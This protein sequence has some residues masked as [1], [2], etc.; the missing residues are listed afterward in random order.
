M[1]KDYG[2]AAILIISAVI[3]SA[4]FMFGIPEQSDAATP[5]AHDG[6]IQLESTSDDHLHFIYFTDDYLEL[7]LIDY[8]DL[9]WENAV[10]IVLEQDGKVLTFGPTSA[11]P[12]KG[13]INAF[14]RVW[15]NTFTGTDD[16]F[17]PNKDFTFTVYAH[18][19]HSIILGSCSSLKQVVVTLENKSVQ[20]SGSAQAIGAASVTDI[21]GNPIEGLTVSY[22]YYSD[23]ECTQEIDINQNPIKHADTYYA[24]AFTEAS[25]EY[26][27]GVSNVATLTITPKPLTPTATMTK[28]Y[29]GSKFLQG[30]ASPS[31]NTGISGETVTVSVDS[32]TYNDGVDVGTYSVDLNV[33]LSDQDTDYCLVNQNEQG[34]ASITINNATITPKP[35]AWPSIPSKTYNG[36]TQVAEPDVSEKEYAVGTN[37]GGEDAGFYDIELIL[38]S[39]NYMWKD[40]GDYELSWIQKSFEIVKADVGGIITQYSHVYDGSPHGPAKSDL[41]YTGFNGKSPSDTYVTISDKEGD[42]R[43]SKGTHYVLVSVSGGDKNFNATSEPIEVSF[44]IGKQQVAWPTDIPYAVYD[45]TEKTLTYGTTGKPYTLTGTTKGTDAGF[46]PVTLTLVSDDYVWSGKSDEDLAWTQDS[47][48]IKKGTITGISTTF[49]HEY[50]GTSHVPAKTD[51]AYTGFSTRPADTSVTLTLKEG[52]DGISAGSHT[53]LVSVS[54]DGNFEDTTEPIEISYSISQKGLTINVTSQKYYDGSFLESAITDITADGLVDGDSVS[55]GKVKTT[56]SDVSTYTEQTTDWIISEDFATTKGLSNYD[57]SFGTVTLKIEKAT[58]TE[59]D[60][61][62]EYASGLIYDGTDLTLITTDLTKTGPKFQYHIGDSTDF[63]DDVPTGKTADTYKVYW[64][65]VGGK[66]YNDVAG[67]Y[68]NVNIA[69]RPIIITVSSQSVYSGSQYEYTIK[70]TDLTNLASGDSLSAGKLKTAGSDVS[71]YTASGTSI[72]TQLTISEAIITSYGIG[73]YSI[74][75]NVSLKIT[76]ADPEYTA[77]VGKTGL[78]YDGDEKELITAGSSDDGTFTYSLDGSTYASAIPTAIEPGSYTVYWKLTGDGNHKDASGSVTGITIVNGA[79]SFSWTD[80][81]D[82]TYSGTPKVP[83]VTINGL[84]AEDEGKVSATIKLSDG[85]DNVN[86]GT[87]TYYV[88][89]LTGES[90]SKYD[91]PEQV[92]SSDY[93]ITKKSLAVNISASKTYDGSAFVYTIKQSDLSGLV[94]G[95]SLTKGKITTNSAAVGTYDSQDEYQIS[96]ALAVQNGIANYDVGY[97]VSLVISEARYVLTFDPGMFTVKIGSSDIASGSRVAYNT[98]VTVTASD[99]YTIKSISLDGTQQTSTTGFS[100]PLKDTVLTVETEGA[101]HTITYSVSPEEG[102]SVDE[103][104]TSALSGQT[105]V[106]ADYIHPNEGYSLQSLTYKLNGAGDDVQISKTGFEMPN[107]DITVYVVFVQDAPTLY[108]ITVSAMDN[109]TVTSSSYEA[110]ENEEIALIVV[111]ENGYVLKAGTLV[112]MGETEIELSGSGNT[113]TFTMPAHAVTISA[114][115]ERLYTVT[116]IE[117]EHGILQSSPTSGKAGTEVELTPSA[118][119]GYELDGVYAGDQKITPVNDKYIFTLQA[120]VE[121]SAVFV[122]LYTLTIDDGITGGTVTPSEEGPFKAGASVTLTITPGEEKDLSQ[123]WVAG[124]QVTPVKSGEAYTY[125]FQIQGD[126]FVTAE[127]SDLYSVTINNVTGGTITSSLSGSAPAGTQVTLTVTLST[128]YKLD[129]LVINGEIITISGSTYVFSLQG[130]TTVTAA[131][132]ALSEYTVTFNSNGGTSV[133]SQTVAAGGKVVKPT[134]PTKPSTSTMRYTFAGWYS[135]SALTTAYDFDSIVNSS[136][137]LYAKWIETPI[138]GPSPGPEPTPT[139]SKDKEYNPDG[140]TTESETTTKKDPITGETTT[141]TKSTTTETDGTKTETESKT[142]TGKDG[143]S[144]TESTSTTTNPDGSS[145]TSSTSS[146]STKNSDGTTST[147]SDTMAQSSDGSSSVSKTTSTTSKDGKTT[148]GTTTTTETDADGNVSRTTT[149]FISET[150]KSG[151]DTITTTTETST[152]VNPDGTVTTSTVETK[153]T[154]SSDGSSTEDVTIQ[155]TNPD[156]SKTTETVTTT[157]SKNGKVEKETDTTIEYKDGSSESISSLSET[158][159]SG[160]TTVTETETT[161]TRSD[162]SISKEKDVT[163]IYTNGKV[164]TER[165]TDSVDKDGNETIT[166][167]TTTKT[168]SDVTTESS[169]T[170]TYADGTVTTVKTRTVDDGS[171]IESTVSE[172]TVETDGTV[173]V[174]KTDSVTKDDVTEM[175]INETITFPDG[176]QRVSESSVEQTV[177]EDGSVVSERTLS[178]TDSDGTV[179]ESQSTTTVGE[180]GSMQ[181]S[182]DDR[183]TNPDGSTTDVSLNGTDRRVEVIVS[184]TKEKDIENAMQSLEDIDADIIVIGTENSDGTIILPKESVQL[185]ADAGYQISVNGGSQYVSLDDDVVSYLAD[186]DGDVVLSVVK[187][188]A[189]NTSKA[190]MDTIGDLYAVQVTLTVNGQEVHELNGKAEIQIEPGYA[191]VYVYYVDSNGDTQL[192]SSHYDE[193]TGKVTFDVEHFSCYMVSAEEYVKPT[194]DQNMVLWIVLIIV[195]VLIIIAA[196]AYYRR[197]QKA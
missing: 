120:D 167:S 178:S 86:V 116:V 174:R 1:R 168:S 67:S 93:T 21:N 11:F 134:D 62:V 126:T 15:D 159:R 152:T 186:Q 122:K 58:L 97:T 123:L 115:F 175:D 153:D 8:D 7:H 84:A 149:E 3:L 101:S 102:G 133:A 89:G 17:V 57:W 50:D 40:K 106:L 170:I 150:T 55:A 104:I 43:I 69:Q 18:G 6:T 26:P 108:K 24:K 135:N 127:F 112:A 140:S 9:P 83:T 111:P 27:A 164:V 32:F 110:A 23:A 16:K 141:E 95:D 187:A 166:E 78:I 193:T 46:Y 177:R 30:I 160:S 52:D 54:G 14:Y 66:N 142:V 172:S 39:T 74:T 191:A 19:N 183:F 185:L 94:S 64:R 29:D 114:E 92:V 85:K 117:P 12:W 28:V 118:S 65:I 70:N 38:K 13:S 143:S 22:K 41:I 73:N 77:P 155:T 109:G 20:Y 88:T 96:E 34:I 144:T 156:G 119:D 146:Q 72:G 47:F 53:I 82:L 107:S 154:R 79:I 103:T 188:T 42:S 10:D 35:I 48:E 181:V 129:N 130:D 132:S 91:M 105:V 37:A 90:A 162:G 124:S 190:Q 68:G 161:T 173:I 44:T 151:K 194:G 131:Y 81:S 157:V 139:P 137:T 136:F 176:S 182:S 36:D 71:D 113:W 125:T 148:E 60:Y 192:I 51:L 98:A 76:K 31:A 100:M 33:K 138:P 25:G 169:S 80:P 99:G 163:T 145:S 4:A 56:G 196:I 61:T 128:G 75:Y 165:N 59:D 5:H 171:E 121:V 158:T 45:G 180:D 63:T 49:T 184:D 179:R 147:V 189:D 195:I 2:I 197:N 87:F